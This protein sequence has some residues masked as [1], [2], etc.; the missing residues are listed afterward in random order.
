[1][2]QIPLQAIPAQRLNV[3]LDDQNCTI[4]LYQRGRSLYM[5]LA[6][7]SDTICNGAICRNGASIVQSPSLHFDGTLHFF[8]TLGNED[9]QYSKLDTRW[10]L[11]YVPDG[12]DLPEKLQF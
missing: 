12:E 6:V 1:M 10:I 5:D 2:Y 7:D 8:D 9:P 4:A 11:L 3:V